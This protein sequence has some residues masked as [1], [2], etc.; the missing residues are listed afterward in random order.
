MR[1]GKREEGATGGWDSGQRATGRRQ[2]ATGEL[3]VHG[4][5]HRATS[6]IIILHNLYRFFS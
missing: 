3:L 6:Y 2:R 1:M 4:F 5:M